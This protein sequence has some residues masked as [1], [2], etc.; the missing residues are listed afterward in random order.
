M[1]YQTGILGSKSKVYIMWQG[2]WLGVGV[3]DV[4]SI[5]WDQSGITE[6]IR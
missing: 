2:H 6:I 4:K 3:K 5:F 1:D